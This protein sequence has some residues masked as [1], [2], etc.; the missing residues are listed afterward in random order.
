MGIFFEH[1]SAICEEQRQAG[2]KK[3]DHPND[4]PKL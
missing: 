3:N 2:W 1:K 4:K